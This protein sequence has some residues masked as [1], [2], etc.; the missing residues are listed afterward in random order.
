V[1]VDSGEEFTVRGADISAVPTP[2]T[3]ACDGHPLVPIV[4]C[5]APSPAM[6]GAIDLIGL[7]PF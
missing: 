3:P 1:T 7:T 5:G 2:L 6:S 4:V